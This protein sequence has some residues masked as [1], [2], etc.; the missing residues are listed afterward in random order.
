MRGPPNSK[1]APGRQPEGLEVSD[2]GERR[3]AQILAL[4]AP[5]LQVAGPL[6]VNARGASALCGLALRSWWRL[7]AQ[8]RVPAPIKV[9]RR[10]LW[11][12]RPDLHEW[13]AQGCPS[14]EAVR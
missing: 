9:G 3:D 2:A 7:H 14:R 11:R 12:V 6:L 10:T 5:D 4:A 13:V 1:R 8:G